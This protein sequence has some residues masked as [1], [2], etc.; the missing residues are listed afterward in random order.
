[1]TNSLRPL[2]LTLVALFLIGL[3]GSAGAFEVWAFIDVNGS[4][5]PG[6]TD[7]N[8]LKDGGV[9]VN[10]FG[11]SVSRPIGTGGFPQ[12]QTQKSAITITKPVDG[13]SPLIF[14]A[15]TNNET[16][17]ALFRFFR[18]NPTSGA[19]EFYYEV[20]ISNGVVGSQVLIG[21]VSDEMESIKLYFLTLEQTSPIAGTSHTN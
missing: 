18:P 7:A 5:L 13:I 15:V 14:K 16:I 2:C 8:P 4:A 3:P 21:G 6:V 10:S 19:D 20:R 17:N 11:F 12:G 1:M 9:P